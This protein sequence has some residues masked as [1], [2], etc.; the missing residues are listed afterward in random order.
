MA[1]KRGPKEMTD[2]HK[3]ALERGRAEGRVVRDYLE[4][5]RSSKPKRGRKRTAESINKRLAKIEEELAEA[6]AIDELQLLQERRD[7]Q[8]EIQSMDGGVDVSELE[9]AFID[10]AKG[11]GDRKG[12][13]YATWRDVG[14]SAA[15]LK[16]AGIGRGA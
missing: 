15:T 5:L 13:S 7:L 10:V 1:A 8:A 14:V 2:S 6:T 11:Y 12:I 3:A 9:A 4:A 16:R